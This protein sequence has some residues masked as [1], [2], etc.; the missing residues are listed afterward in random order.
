MITE[1]PKF[2]K[3]TMATTH[4]DDPLATTEDSTS[5][6]S[7][8]KEQVQ[9]NRFGQVKTQRWHRPKPKI[10][11]KQ[12]EKVPTRRSQRLSNKKKQNIQV[13]KSSIGD[14]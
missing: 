12:L 10:D 9:T 5:N 6:D 4:A 11:L 2:P 7:S 3:K 14:F 13:L 8:D 1:K